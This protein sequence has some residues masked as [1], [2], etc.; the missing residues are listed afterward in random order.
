MPCERRN[1]V[2]RLGANRRS[3]PRQCG[4][5]THQAPHNW[6]L[7]IMADR[8]LSRASNQDGSLALASSLQKSYA[9]STTD[10][11]RPHPRRNR[12]R[13]RS[14]D[15]P[16]ADPLLTRF[17]QRRTRDRNDR[18]E[19][20][21]CHPGYDEFANVID[22]SSSAEWLCFENADCASDVPKRAPRFSSVRCAPPADH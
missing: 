6:E 14:P 4:T 1:Y 3:V 21:G 9:A 19:I 8:S 11:A 5:S 17:G 7:Y 15:L 20:S 13:N 12:R 18:G 10:I 22:H 16:N 2:E